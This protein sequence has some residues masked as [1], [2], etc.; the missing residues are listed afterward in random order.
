LVISQHGDYRKLLRL[1][2]Y[3][4]DIVFR[5][6]K[7]FF[8]FF[9]F[10]QEKFKRGFRRLFRRCHEPPGRRRRFSSAGEVTLSGAFHIEDADPSSMTAGHH[11]T[12]SRRRQ[13][14][15]SD[16][17]SIN[18]YVEERRSSRSSE[19][20]STVSVHCQQSPRAVHCT[21]TAGSGTHLTVPGSGRYRQLNRSN[22]DAADET[23]QLAEL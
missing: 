12:A 13:P 15:G 18:Y 9:Y 19:R 5:S 22:A 20:T 16:A 1:S 11:R 3:W 17:S 2:A 14:R 7:S 8:L 23:V 10:T 4:A 21:T 6:L